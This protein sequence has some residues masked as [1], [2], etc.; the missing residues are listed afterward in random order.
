MNHFSKSFSIFIAVVLAFSFF[1]CS[2]DDSPAATGTESSFTD[3]YSSE[4]SGYVTW[5]E[6][7]AAAVAY[8]VPEIESG[9]YHCAV[10]EPK[11]AD[12]P[13]GTA[14]ELSANGKTV[15]LLVTDLCPSSENAQ[16]TSKAT[17]FF[18]LE[19]SA[20]TSL[21][22]ASVGELQMTFKT[23]PYPTAKNIKMQVKDGVNEWWLAFRFYNMRYPLKKVEFSADG[24]NFTEVAK[25]S[26][27]EN[28]W[29]KTESSTGGLLSGAHYFRLTDVHDQ[30]VTT[31]NLGAFTANGTV[32]TQKNFA[33]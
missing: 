3:K 11:Y 20:F 33:P 32:D 21:A 30:Q 15:H 12:L 2:S 22:E 29:Y 24:T 26:G 27:I 8:Y 1:S 16:H 9:W 19:K 23:I 28:N 13:A 10:S 31:A 25:L 4:T 5:Y 14:I 18:D 17:Y 6:G 7:A